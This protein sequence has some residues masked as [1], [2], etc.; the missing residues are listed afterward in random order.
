M[1]HHDHE[2]VPPHVKA[3]DAS[4]SAEGR[5]AP[6]ALDPTVLTIGTGLDG[7]SADVLAIAVL[8]DCQL[9][10]ILHLLDVLVGELVGVYR[11]TAWLW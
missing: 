2:K 11:E 4:E 1:S 9:A 8:D 5:D 7:L 10:V 3:V 6:Q